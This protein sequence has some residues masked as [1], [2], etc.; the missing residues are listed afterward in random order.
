MRQ[1]LDI[2]TKRKNAGTLG[3]LTEGGKPIPNDTVKSMPDIDPAMV[4]AVTMQESS[5]GKTGIIDIMQA[6]VGGDWGM[7]K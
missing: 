3:L 7:G 5:A 2:L 6:N 1:G 4:K